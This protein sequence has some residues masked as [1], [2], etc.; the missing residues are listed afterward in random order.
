VKVR[1][2]FLPGH[3]LVAVS[4]IQ[5]FVNAVRHVKNNTMVTNIK[6]TVIDDYHCK[7]KYERYDCRD[8]D[9]YHCKQMLLLT[10]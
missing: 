8:I 2:P 9:D 5:F 4:T 6:M 7:Q 1:R 3:N 10:F